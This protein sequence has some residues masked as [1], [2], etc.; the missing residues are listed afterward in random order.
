MTLRRS[1]AAAAVALAVPVVSSC[2]S[3]FQPPTDQVYQPGVGAN[4]RS[5]QVDVLNALIVSGEDGSGTVIAGLVNNNTD[6]PDKLTSV[7]GAGADRSISVSSS[8]AQVEIDPDGFYQL[9]DKGEISVT[10]DQIKPGRFVEL[11]FSFENAESI[12]ID[13]PVV[14]NTD[15]FA[16]VP[17]PSGS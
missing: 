10:G 9:A 15:E 2:G 13:V 16:D 17:V 7:S 12:D 14:A 8:G 1:I 11:T 3:N 4:D 6:E 5:G